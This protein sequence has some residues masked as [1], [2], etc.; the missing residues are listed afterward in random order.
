MSEPIDELRQPASRPLDRGESL[1]A[2]WYTDPAITEREI[3]QIFRKTW[4]YVGPANE[5]T[6]LGDY[7]TGYVGEMPVVVIRNESGLAAFVNVCRHRRHE[8]MKGRGNAKVMQCGYHA[9]TYDLTGCLKGAPR[10]RHRAEFPAGGLSAAAA[11]GRDA[12]PMGVR[13]RRPRRRAVARPLRQGLDII[14]GSGIDLDTLELYSRDEWESLLQLEDDARELSRMLSLRGRASG[15]QRGDR[16]AAGELPPGRPWLVLQPGRPVRQSAL[17]GRSQVKIYDARGE[18]AQSQ[19]HLLLPEPDDQ[20]Q[21]GLPEPVDRRLDAE[22]P[23]RRPRASP[24]SI[25]ARASRE[26]FAQELIAF[27][28]QVG[29]EDDDLTNSVQRGLLARHSRPRPVP[30]QQRASRRPLPEAGRQCRDRRRRRCG[31]RRGDRRADGIAHD[32]GCCPTRPAAPDSERNAYVALEVFKV[33]PE[34]EIITSFYLRRADGRPLHP[35]EPGQFLPI[36]VTIPGQAQPALRTYTLST[37]A[38]S[39]PLPADR[40]GAAEGDALVSRFLHANAK[41][42][43]RDRGDGAARQ[44]RARPVERAPGRADLRRRRHHADDRDGRAYRRGRQADRQLPPGLLH[45]RHAERRRPR[46][47]ASSSRELAAEHPAFKLHVRYSRPGDDRRARRD[48]DGDGHVTIDVL[49]QVLPFGDYEFYLC[50]PP[51]FMQSLYDGLTGIGVPRRADLLRILRS[52]D[53]AE[54]RGAAGRAGTATPRRRRGP[55]ALRPIRCRREWSR[56]RGTLA[57]TRRIDRHRAEFR[58]PLRDLRHLHDADL[59]R[60]GRVYR[61]AGRAARRGR[62]AAV[63]LGAARRR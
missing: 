25:S 11:A 26:E 3:Q 60:R 28:R 10:T 52:G 14:A 4:T 5:L 20:H 40:S 58:L 9:W 47:S 54:A 30:D 7:I 48:H 44:V 43:F 13:Q 23:E 39:R 21:P 46:L 16:R 6:N 55:G 45:P 36:R 63:L 18:V 57:G 1:P 8:V 49:K 35:W 53:G 12:R 29:K 56:D 62:G 31:R 2:R 38:Q 33:E 59:E 27:N 42:G 61:G 51:A 24:S 15:L 19:Y 17:E 34:S 37:T 50:G 22:R 32:L 41:P